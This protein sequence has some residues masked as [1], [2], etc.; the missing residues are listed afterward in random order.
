VIRS[1]YVENG[2]ASVQ[3][4]AGV[5]YDSVPQAEADE[6]RSKAQAVI[7]AIRKAHSPSATGT[8]NTER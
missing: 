4:G 7:T 1:A 5:V 2:I 6:T 8:K 3:A